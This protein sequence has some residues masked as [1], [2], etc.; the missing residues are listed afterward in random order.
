MEIMKHPNLHTYIARYLSAGG[1]LAIALLAAAPPA[2]AIPILDGNSNS[3]TFSNLSCASCGT[4]TG[5]TS[6]QEITLPSSGNGGSNSVLTIINPFTFNTDSDAT[7]NLAE[8]SLTLGKKPGTG[9]TDV[10]TFNY[11]L[12]L[13]LLTPSGGGFSQTFSA[14]LVGNIGSGSNGV[15]TLSGLELT[16]TDPLALSGVTLSNFQFLT[17]ATETLSTFSTI[18]K[19]W[20]VSGPQTTAH[21]FLVADVTATTISN[22]EP[23]P[24]SVPEPT[25]LALLSLGLA[26]VGFTRRRINA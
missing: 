1:Y 18:N 26:G 17:D 8:L 2:H 24:V 3:S 6:A 20:E 25:T 4:G 5:L 16:L 22:P 10:A 7:L 21:L 9:T 19:I 11:N 23:D 14:G 13:T 12:V 15:M